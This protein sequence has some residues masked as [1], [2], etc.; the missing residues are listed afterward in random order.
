[1]R[2]KKK[3]VNEHTV[4]SLSGDMEVYDAERFESEVE[5]SLKKSKGNLIVDFGGLMYISSSGLSVL[6]NIRDRL[7]KSGGKLILVS[8][9]GKVLEVFR[10]SKLLDI[11]DVRA[12]VEDAMR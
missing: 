9:K 11:F 5:D 6:L 8:L 12:S 7:Q 10:V 4:V 2:M 3:A 1:M